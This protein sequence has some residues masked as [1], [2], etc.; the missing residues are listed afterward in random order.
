MFL[1]SDLIESEESNI[2]FIYD[3]IDSSNLKKRYLLTL[4]TV[5]AD[6]TKFRINIYEDDIVFFDIKI[7]S[8]DLIPEY[9]DEFL[10]DYYELI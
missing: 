10:L 1:R 4:H 8:E 2:F 5:R 9:K 3:A 6:G 7:K